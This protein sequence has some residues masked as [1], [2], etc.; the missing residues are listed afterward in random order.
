[1][2]LVKGTKAERKP[3]I[4]NQR[5]KTD[6]DQI[7]NEKSFFH[8]QNP[9]KLLKMAAQ[10]V[11]IFNSIVVPEY[12]AFQLIWFKSNDKIA[13]SALIFKNNKQKIICLGRELDPTFLFYLNRIEI[14]E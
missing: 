7:V 5:C 11:D 1:M 8:W 10:G 13:V 3:T 4:A 6:P 2:R 12:C 9:K 14:S